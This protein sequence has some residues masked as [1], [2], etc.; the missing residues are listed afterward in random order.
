M[1]C[2]VGDAAV[3]VGSTNN[4]GDVVTE[5]QMEWQTQLICFK[6]QFFVK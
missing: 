4:R 6:S 2:K 3:I 1:S 5:A